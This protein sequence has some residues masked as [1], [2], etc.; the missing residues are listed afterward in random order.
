[1]FSKLLIFA[2]FLAVGIAYA[3]NCKVAHDDV[4]TQVCH[5][6]PTQVCGA[7][8]DGTVVFQHVEP[9]T[10]TVDVVDTFCVPAVVAADG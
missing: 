10:L 4:E 8:D 1:M 7:E 9:D 5:I 6:Q 3:P 2:S